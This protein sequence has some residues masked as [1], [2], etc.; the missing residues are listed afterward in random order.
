MKRYR[1][2]TP[3]EVQKWRGLIETAF[4]F[5]LALAM[6]ALIAFGVRLA[7]GI[8]SDDDIRTTQE[9]VADDCRHRCAKAGLRFESVDLG[10]HFK[11]VCG[12]P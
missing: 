5:G 2:P 10:D 9:R 1:G 3:E 11:C 6:T 12:A 4:D 7:V 8:F